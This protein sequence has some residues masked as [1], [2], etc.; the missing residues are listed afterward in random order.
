M[1]LRVEGAELWP[2]IRNDRAAFRERT[3]GGHDRSLDETARPAEAAATPLVEVPIG[4]E[5]VGLAGHQ[6]L[7][8]D[9]MLEAIRRMMPWAEVGANLANPRAVML[10]GG[11]LLNA[12]NYY[13]NK[14]RRVDG[15]NLERMVFGAGVRSPDY[16]GFTEELEDW[17]PF[18]RSALSIGLRGPDSLAT[19]RSWV[20]TGRST[21]SVTLLLCSRGRK[22]SRMSRAGSS[23]VRCTRPASAGAATMAPYSTSSP[24]RSVA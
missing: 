5:Y 3:R 2:L 19:I 21:L 11:T 6:N 12:E 10:G 20:T 13:L 9:A 1:D 4:I 17:E 23:S 18:L 7:G 15:P 8:D 24:L 22:G 14:V 16:W